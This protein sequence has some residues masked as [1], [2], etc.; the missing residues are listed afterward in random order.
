VRKF[1]LKVNLLDPG[2]VATALRAEAF[3]GENPATLAQP[4]AVTDAF[5]ELASAACTRT[6]EVVAASR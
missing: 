1:G 2:I 6:G 4:D 3:P 5:V